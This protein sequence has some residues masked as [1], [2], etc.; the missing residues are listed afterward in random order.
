MSCEATAVCRCALV[1]KSKSIHRPF[2]IRN[3]FSARRVARDCLKEGD[4]ETPKA[5]DENQ[6]NL[7]TVAS[8]Q[9]AIPAIYAQQAMHYPI[10]HQHLM[11]PYPCAN[12]PPSVYPYQ[13]GFSLA[14][15]SPQVGLSASSLETNLSDDLPK[16]KN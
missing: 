9:Q 14:S 12:Y 16:A 13:V 5:S 15:A 3:L 11:P 8:P 10:N 6:K 2:S 1:S 4:E 7:N